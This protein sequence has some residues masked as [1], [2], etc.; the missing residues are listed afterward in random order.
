MYNIP[1]I[2]IEFYFFKKLLNET[3]DFLNNTIKNKLI[4]FTGSVGD[5]NVIDNLT[6]YKLSRI[7]HKPL[8]IG[9]PEFKKEGLLEKYNFSIEQIDEMNYIHGIQITKIDMNIILNNSKLSIFDSIR[10]LINYSN[11]DKYDFTEFDDEDVDDDYP[12]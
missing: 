1:I 5:I 2:C 10:E 11:S 3:I 12:F 4:Y 6:K 8:I 7:L 9:Q